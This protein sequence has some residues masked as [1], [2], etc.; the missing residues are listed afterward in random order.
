MDSGVRILLA[1][2]ILQDHF[3]KVAERAGGVLL[4]RGPLS[5]D[6]IMRFT[7]QPDGLGSE[8]ISFQRVRN[9]LLALIQHGIVIAKPNPSVGSSDS[10]RGLLQIYH[11]DIS[12]ILCRLRYPQFLEHA[13]WMYGDLAYGVLL[14][15]LQHGRASA[16]Y[17]IAEARRALRHAKDTELQAELRVLTE[18][19]LI[20]AAAP[21]SAGV[22]PV[23]DDPANAGAA[24]PSAEHLV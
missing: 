11:I 21:C 13:K 14:V 24:S 3:G 22:V 19:G 15:I 7:S 2:D 17:V 10:L 18:Q 4:E 20:Q 6:E 23:A 16:G 8:P 1:R 9:A 12:E 5:L